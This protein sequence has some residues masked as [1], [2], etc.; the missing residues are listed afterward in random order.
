MVFLMLS[1]LR[2]LLEKGANVCG[3]QTCVAVGDRVAVGEAVG[4]PSKPS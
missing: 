2:S 1:S 3:V 4:D